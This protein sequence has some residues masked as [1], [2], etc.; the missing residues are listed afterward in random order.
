MLNLLLIRLNLEAYQVLATSMSGINLF[1]VS[2][3]TGR[4]VSRAGQPLLDYTHSR[5]LTGPTHIDKLQEPLID[6]SINDVS[7]LRC[8]YIRWTD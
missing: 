8:R 3:S 1:G 4:P 2:A 6:F 7:R 5:E